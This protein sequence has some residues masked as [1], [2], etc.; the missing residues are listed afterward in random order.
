MRRLSFVILVLFLCLFTVPR[1]RDA[2]REAFAAPGL[3]G[4]PIPDTPPPGWTKE[5]LDDLRK[6]E[7]QLRHGDTRPLPSPG[8]AEMFYDVTLTARDAGASGK[9][10]PLCVRE[11]RAYTDLGLMS[12]SCGPGQC[13]GYEFFFLRTDVLSTP[14]AIRI[15]GAVMDV[16]PSR[17]A[18]ENAVLR[19]LDAVPALRAVPLPP[20]VLTV[21]GRPLPKM[22]A[23]GQEGSGTARFRVHLA[24][25]FTDAGAPH[26][27]CYSL[28]L[29]Q[30]PGK[31]S[32]FSG[33][34]ILTNI[35]DYQASG[36]WVGIYPIFCAP[37][38]TERIDITGSTFWKDSEAA[39]PS[40]LNGEPLLLDDE[41]TPLPFV[42]S[43]GPLPPPAEGMYPLRPRLI[44]LGDPED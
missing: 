20:M 32:T 13:L 3:A 8:K 38:G 11:V 37:Q 10:R 22:P 5:Q 29:A 42:T 19:G 27:R 12:M 1:S 35:G 26:W 17:D 24:D 23:A 25:A 33:A 14:E 21:S 40:P 6:L 36:S 43:K 44:T 2:G 15:R 18:P 34:H 9:K 41:F 7:I 39:T 16:A 31:A 28:C 4:N 30:L